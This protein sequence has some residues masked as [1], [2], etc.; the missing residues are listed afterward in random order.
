MGF[1]DK[2]IDKLNESAQTLVGQSGTP[3]EPYGGAAAQG[4][5]PM[6]AS[7]IP[8]NETEGTASTAPTVQTG[9]DKPDGGTHPADVPTAQTGGD[10]TSGKKPDVNGPTKEYI[11]KGDTIVY[12]PSFEKNKGAASNPPAGS[13]TPEASDTPAAVEDLP[14]ELV[15]DGKSSK[16]VPFTAKDSRVKVNLPASIGNEPSV[17]VIECEDHGRPQVIR[18]L[19]AN[20]FPMVFGSD[21]TLNRDE[22]SS[23]TLNADNMFVWGRHCKLCIQDG[24]LVLT[25]LSENAYDTQLVFGEMRHPIRVRRDRS[26]KIEAS[27]FV[28]SMEWFTIKCRL[29]PDMA[30]LLY[31]Q[32]NLTITNEQGEFS[33]SV[34]DGARIVGS[35]Y[36]LQAADLVKIPD[37]GA[38]PIGVVHIGEDEDSI[39][40]VGR[41]VFR[42]EQGDLSQKVVLSE[43]SAFEVLAADTHVTRMKVDSVYRPEILGTGRRTD[44]K[45]SK[46]G[47][48]KYTQPMMVGDKTP[49]FSV[50]FTGKDG[51]FTVRKDDLPLLVTDRFDENNV[52][53]AQ[54]SLSDAERPF[55]VS[56]DIEKGRPV[57][58]VYGT[59]TKAC[60]TPEKGLTFSSTFNDTTKY[61]IDALETVLSVDWTEM[62]ITLLPTAKEFCDDCYLHMTVVNT[63]AKSGEKELYGLPVVRNVKVRSDTDMGRAAGQIPLPD[64][65]RNAP[66]RMACSVVP[67]ET[68]KSGL[69]LKSTSTASIFG[70]PDNTV[71]AKLRLEEGLVF[72]IPPYRFTVGPLV[73]FDS[74][75][76][77]ENR[78]VE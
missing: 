25:S 18:E 14:A 7:V 53:R 23:V 6:N 12:T 58:T 67:D 47:K 52:K 72:E 62:R 21:V 1:I 60:V 10:G 24:A 56:L 3:Y 44:E 74:V 50:R 54:I 40:A 26:Y 35:E 16:V 76:E 59:K 77:E 43:A 49:V 30:K 48:A 61:D 2:L 45:K 55:M 9:G 31:K 57:L 4:E 68:S 36:P 78:P 64:T 37:A 13:D 46:N 69:S 70:L 39:A 32:Y 51:I 27:E 28:L 75:F 73:R 71:A 34:K 66:A 15:K 63:N 22:A 8:T 42:N 19:K 65:D 38:D 33:A 29:L 41:M 11:L 17:M 5:K 20:H